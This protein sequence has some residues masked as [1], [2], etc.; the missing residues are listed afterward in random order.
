[1]PVIVIQ[2]AAPSTV[3]AVAQ[4][5]IT[6]ATGASN[7]YG[8]VFANPVVGVVA[9]LPIP[10]ARVISK[11]T[12]FVVGGTSATFNIEVR[13]TPNGAGTNVQTSEIVAVVAGTVTTT[14]NNPN[15][16]A[17]ELL[18]LDLSAVV[19]SPTQCGVLIEF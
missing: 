1:M 6:G 15:V 10:E 2:E 16:S 17:G 19:G 12:S 4:R 9:G 18:F 8:W 11:I 5:G 14:I 13:A 7:P 3:V